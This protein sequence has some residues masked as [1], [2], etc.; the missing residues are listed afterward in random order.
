MAGNGA[1]SAGPSQQRLGLNDHL[2]IPKRRIL[3]AERHVLA[4]EIASCVAL[5]FRVK[6]KGKQ[7]QRLRLLRQ[8]LGQEPRQKQ[9]F[10]CEI[11]ADDIGSP[12]VG[13]TFRKGGINGVQ[14]GLE[15]PANFLALRDVEWHASLPDLVLGTDESLTH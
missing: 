8:Q 6:H 1:R 2:P 7:A 11:A 14:Y 4:L 3:L 5:R 13:P 15:T 9:R 12:R 10:F